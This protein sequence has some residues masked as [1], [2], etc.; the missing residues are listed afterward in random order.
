MLNY[1]QIL[2]KNASEKNLV[3]TGRIT[4]SVSMLFAVLVAEPFIGKSDQAFQVIQEFT[5]FFTPGIVLIFL[6]GFHYLFGLFLLFK[7][8]ITFYYILL[9][10]L[11]QIYKKL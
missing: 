4:A 6:F 5:G 7:F 1:K 8:Y 11:F 9:F 10:H 2:N 3:L